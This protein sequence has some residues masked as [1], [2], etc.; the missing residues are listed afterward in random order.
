MNLSSLSVKRP[1]TT[2]MC[3]LVALCFGLM[4]M[5][6]LSMDMMP[7]MNIPIV[8]IM[9]TYEGASSE[10]IKNLVTKPMEDAVATVSGLDTLQSQS[11][12][13]NSMVMAR[14]DYSVDVDVAAQDV[15]ERVDMYKSML[16]EGAKDPM[17]LK[18]DI[19]SMMGNIMI[20]ASSDSK[21]I[22]ELKNTIDD[23][24]VPRIERQK[25]VA[26]VSTVGGND[27]IIEV[28]L[29]QEKMRA[30][31]IGESTVTGT[32]VSE[33]I[34]TPLGSVYKGD[35]NLTLRIKGEYRDINEIQ[36]VLIPTGTGG[37]VFLS[38]IADVNEKYDESKA[39]SYTDGKESITMSVSKT[40]TANTVDVSKAVFAEMAKIQEE[41]P[42]INFV[43]VSDPA[44]YIQLALKSVADSLWQ[45]GV[46]AIIVLFIFLREIRSTLVVAVS[47]P[48][49]IVTTF[50][51]MRLMNVNFN[52]MSLGGLTLGIGMLVDNSIVVMESIYKKLEEG[53]DRIRAAIEGGSEVVNSVLAST[54][55]TVAVFLPITM[56]EGQVSELFNDMCLTIVFSLL[57]SLVVAVTFVPM[58]CSLLL[59]PENVEKKK[60]K[61]IVSRFLDLIGKFLELLEKGY[62]K[63]IH[64]AL[65]MKKLTVAVAVLFVFLTGIV[66]KDMNSEF[67]SSTDEGEIS[68]SVSLPKGSSITRTEEIVW[69]VVD[70]IENDP[71]IKHMSMSAGSSGNGMSA[72]SGGGEDSCTISINLNKKSEGRTRTTD[73]IAA[74]MRKKVTNIAGAKIEVSSSGS[75][76]GSYSSGGLEI[77][78]FGDDAEAAKKVSEDFVDILKGMDGLADVKS[79][80]EESSPNATIRID[81]RKANSLGI[82][83]SSISNLLRTDITGSKPTKYKINGDEY[84]IKVVLEDGKVN[85]ISDVEQLLI[86]TAGGGSVPLK[87]ICEIVDED[88]PV[89]IARENQKD[90]IAVTATLDG[91]ALSEAQTYFE[92]AFSTYNMP[93]SVS[94]QY[95]GSAKYMAEAFSGLLVA[96]VVAVLLVYMVMA[97]EFEAYSFPFIVMFSIPIAITGGLF[98]N[99]IWGQDISVT[100]FLGLIMLAGVVVNNAIVLIDYA[101]LQVRERG[102][103]YKEAMLIAGPVRLRPIL[104]ST[105]TT[106]LG[107]LPMMLSQADGSES[108]RGLAVTVVFGLS[109]STLVTL[110]LIPAIYVAFNERIDKRKKKRQA[111]KEKRAAKMA[112]KEAAAQA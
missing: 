89:A 37:T 109:F 88:V 69:K 96:L 64:K 13:G 7:N 24:I 34:N 76:M 101:N 107:M 30:Y 19:N 41:M 85:Y 93:A 94:W 71:D 78:V 25:G 92:T 3:V 105:L 1:V 28:S 77:D 52:M 26:S 110:V 104:M 21:S 38:D 108:M 50:A 82:S 72:L 91:A 40:S 51:V 57:C 22:N 75:S 54:L 23:L 59:S 29:N 99:F 12:A 90:K 11:S 6:N 74:E 9:T 8:L 5:L 103:N 112:A 86:P 87:E 106:V 39:F 58:A 47:M 18:I 70:A 67:M 45:G 4:S 73:E 17:I 56:V 27:K 66:V 95:G 97:A 63:L 33:N 100:T 84:D 102:K 62:D 60:R 83:V 98:G 14:F 36:D 80:L 32:L 10:E 65:D 48:V 20:S 55:T 53:K 44:E 31:G 42:D 16:P 79:S 49:S 68:V 43:T 81:K 61:N 46:F 15:R 111:R 35:K 2:I